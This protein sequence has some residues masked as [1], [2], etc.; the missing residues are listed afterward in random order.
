MKRSTLGRLQWQEIEDLPHRLF[1][2]WRGPLIFSFFLYVAAYMLTMF[3]STSCRTNPETE[4]REW[5]VDWSRV[6]DG[7]YNYAHKA[8]NCHAVWLLALCYIPGCLAGY[9]QLIRFAMSLIN[10]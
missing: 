7:W 8:A 4:E 9:L 2:H 3:R 10:D 6:H 1:P 5:G